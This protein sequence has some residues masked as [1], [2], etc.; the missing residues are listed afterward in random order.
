MAGRFIHHIDGFIGQ[1]PLI[2]ITIGQAG[3]GDDRVIADPHAMVQLVFFFQAAQNKHR[4]FNR[5][6]FNKDR[7]EAA[8][9]C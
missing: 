3:G 8:S 9:Q 2:D 4:V 7:L 5:G 1:K 6:F